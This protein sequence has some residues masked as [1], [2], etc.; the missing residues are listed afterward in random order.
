MRSTESADYQSVPRPVAVMV[1]SFANRS[2]TGRHCHERGQVLYAT[3]GLMLSQTDAG[4]WAVPTGHALLIPPGLLHDI[5]MHGDVR[6]L[7]AYVAVTNWKRLAGK[8]CRVVRVSRL[9]DAALEAICFES[10][11][12]GRRGDHLA[13]VILDEVE[14]A[15]VTDLALPLP[16]SPN[17]RRMCEMLL[18]A[19][20]TTDDLDDWADAVAIS[21]RTLTRHFREETG[22]SFGQWRRRLRQLQSLKLEAEGATPKDIAPRVGYRSPHALMAM[23]RREAR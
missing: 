19:P 17:L 9:L 11:V 8:G 22:L 14:H 5:A 4:T 16:M 1:K 13:A 10:V 21:R 15:D 12:Y 3:A 6:M 2:S 23:M 20:D 7:T 18:A